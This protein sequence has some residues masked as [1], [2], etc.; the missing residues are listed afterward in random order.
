MLLKRGVV[1]LDTE[2][3][4]GYRQSLPLALLL[5]CFATSHPDWLAIS[6]SAP[7]LRVRYSEKSESTGS[8]FWRV[9]PSVTSSTPAIFFPCQGDRALIFTHVAPYIAEVIAE[10]ATFSRATG[11]D[12]NRLPVCAGNVER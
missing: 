10:L 2:I 5:A 1:V 9:R 7:P 8:M 11:L 3:T 6:Y 4:R 12:G